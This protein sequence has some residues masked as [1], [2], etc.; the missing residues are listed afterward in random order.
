LKKSFPYLVAE[1]SLAGSGQPVLSVLKTTKGVRDYQ[2]VGRSC[3]VILSDETTFRG[4]EKRL[5]KTAKIRLVPPSIED[6][7]L[8]AIKTESGVDESKDTRPEP[9]PAQH[10]PKRR[11]LRIKVAGGL[12]KKK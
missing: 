6:I 2:L 3:R 5:E 1:I 11:S 7:F 10:P 12:K 9:E 4:L 8:N